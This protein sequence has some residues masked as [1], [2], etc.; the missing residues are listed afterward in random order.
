MKVSTLSFGELPNGEQAKLF[1]FETD[2][3]MRVKI[4]NYGGIITSI[5]VPDRN[6]KSEEIT[7]GF[8]SLDK[9]LQGHPHFGVI[10]GRFANRIA[11]GRFRIFGKE[12]SLPIN[13]G[14]NHLHGGN[15][16]FHTKL[17]NYELQHSEQHAKLI[18]T[19]I[20]KH[21]E[22]GYPGNLRVTIVYTIHNS[23]RINIT[24]QAKT[25]AH[26]HVNLTSHCYFNLSGF[27]GTI[28]DH[29]LFVN[30]NH[31]LEVNENLIPTGELIPVVN[32]PFDLTSPKRLSSC[33]E[34]L[35]DG[36]D[37]CFALNDPGYQ[38]PLC[39]KLSHEESGRTM[40]VFCS[41]PGLQVYTGNSLDGTHI[42]HN[43]TAYIKHGAICLE[44]QH[45]PN[46]PNQ[47]SFPS[48]LLT[49]G[50]TYLHEATLSFGIIS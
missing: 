3:G 26:T 41:Q 13:N 2:N 29:T 17:W 10:V 11:N 48:T 43:N 36:F 39:A 15:E 45:F 12:Y 4:T 20:S 22:E 18:L 27:R 44:T 8:P 31:Y 16:G 47:R 40:S 7:A 49:P 5:E 30:A 23:N 25:D 46:T 6:G 34:L 33:L 14:P 9:Y 37:H 24:F 1:C 32:S 19:Y 21:H 38:S 35:S 42:G 28:H 50:E